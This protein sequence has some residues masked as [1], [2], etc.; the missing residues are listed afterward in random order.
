MLRVL[1]CFS[2]TKMKSHFFVQTILYN[3]QRSS[4][5]VPMAGALKAVKNEQQTETICNNNH[6][7]LLLG[8]FQSFKVVCYVL[9]QT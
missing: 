6:Y 5:K 3:S 1:C 4:V 8:C 7:F 2:V 9:S